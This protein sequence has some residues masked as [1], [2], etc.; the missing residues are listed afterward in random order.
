MLDH[1]LVL[2]HAAIGVFATNAAGD[3]TYVNRR[4]CEMSGQTPAQ[5]M[6]TGWI[7]AIHVEDR[8]RVGAEWSEAARAGE[9]FRT[10]CRFQLPN[11]TALWIMVV[12]T[13]VREAESVRGY[14]G[15]ITD[16]SER[17]PAEPNRLAERI[18]AGVEGM[19]DA[20]AVL[21]AVRDTDA[22][23]CDFRI[24]EAN[25]LLEGIWGR[26]RSHL[27]GALVSRV[28]PDLLGACAR[29]VELGSPVSL[30]VDRES[31]I[32]QAM[33]LPVPD[34]VAV[35]F[36]DVTEQRLQRQELELRS[37]VMGHMADGVCVVREADQ[38]IIYANARF[39]RVHG[40][41]E[42]EL[43]GNL[44][45][46]LRPTD[47]SP[48]EMEARRGGAQRLRAEGEMTMELR[49]GRKDGTSFFCQAT[50]SA[51]ELPRQGRV[52]VVVLRDITAEKK[53]STDLSRLAFLVNSS[54]DAIVALDP[55]DRIVTWNDAAERLF[56]RS[57]EDVLGQSLGA[58]APPDRA[59]HMLG[60]LAQ[61]KAG[62]RVDAWETSWRR[63]DDV[64]PVLSL[65]ISPVID[66]RGAAVGVSLIVRDVTARKEVERVIRDS[67]AQKDVLLREI[68]HRVKNNLQ[69][70]SSL[71]SLQSRRLTDQGASA[72]LRE[73]QARVRS[74]ALLHE[75]LYRTGD[76]ARVVM[77][78]Y[79]R[80]LTVEVLRSCGSP[81]RVRAEVEGGTVS[82]A[83]DEA[84]P[85]GLILNELLT[86][87]VKHAFPGERTGKVTVAFSQ[88][89][90]WITL[91][92]A[93]DGTGLP[94]GAQPAAAPTLGMHLIHTLANQ[95]DGVATF[96]SHN[97]T[98]CEIRFPAKESRA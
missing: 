54:G 42:G 8:A 31:Q 37:V 5:A 52:W 92:V 38:Q 21:D 97:G 78:D 17:R 76:V 53:A 98:A 7:A 9:P 81:E 15:T 44:V 83:L 22:E 12:A 67:L 63:P 69:V 89:E 90:D 29:A 11:Q 4:W 77:S 65:Q 51:L 41:D 20:F 25:T 50:S 27:I 19:P 68:H 61:A 79:A 34:G 87:A 47:L 46:V 49:N 24:A 73:S 86:N 93:D 16:I 1:A 94:D 30:E 10:E 43:D 55:D 84:V 6:G 33:I 13:A 2:E 48:L 59:A 35:I 32:L 88:H 96:R 85:C 66:G 14:V 39:C 36:R 45:T 70:I 40:W 80:R 28:A 74:I 18:R 71:F 26:P 62:E 91:R 23:V 82:L 3:C 75:R 56:G 57:K 95:L 60:L 64:T 58:V 72:A